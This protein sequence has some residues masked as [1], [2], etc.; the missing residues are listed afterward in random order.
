MFLSTVVSEKKNEGL[1]V[2]IIIKQKTYLK[3]NSTL[4]LG[5]Y[6]NRGKSGVYGLG[7][8]HNWGQ[9]LLEFLI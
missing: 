2:G 8:G 9:K 5:S 6:H 4:S 3:K 7:S 1:N